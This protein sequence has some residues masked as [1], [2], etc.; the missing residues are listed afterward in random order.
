VTK[1]KEPVFEQRVCECG[2]PFVIQSGGLG[3]NGKRQKWCSRACWQKDY[4][5]RYRAVNPDAMERHRQE[6]KARYWADPHKMLTKRR[7]A[8]YGMDKGTFDALLLAQD[9]RCAICRQPEKTVLRGKVK[10]LSVDHNHGTGQVRGLLC[11]R[12]N[13][14]IGLC[15]EGIEVLAETIA[16]LDRWGVQFEVTDD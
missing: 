4:Q 3:W 10:Q 14:I 2:E 5:V 13:F 9:G 15:D 12:C 1:R 16:Y 6:E 7:E 11:A 8:L